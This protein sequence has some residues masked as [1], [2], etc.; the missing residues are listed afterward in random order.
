MTSEEKTSLLQHEN[1]QVVDLGLQDQYIDFDIPVWDLF[2]ELFTTRKK[3]RRRI[4]LCFTGAKKQTMGS[5]KVHYIRRSEM[6]GY[7]LAYMCRFFPEAC[8]EKYIILLKRDNQFLWNEKYYQFI[9]NY[10][11]STPI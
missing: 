11:M 3:L 9:D 4:E 6:K 5:F 10:I 7:L 1:K 8:R 2:R